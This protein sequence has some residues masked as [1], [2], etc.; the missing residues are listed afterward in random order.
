MNTDCSNNW[1]TIW[2][3]KSAQA[4]DSEE[5]L[6][7]LIKANGFDSGAGDYSVLQWET[8]VAGLIKR[9]AIKKEHKVFE[10]GCG[11]GALLYQLS[12]VSGCA[13]YGIDYSQSLIDSAVKLLKG[14]FKACAANQIPFPDESFDIAISHSV[15][16]YFPSFDYA[17]DVMQRMQKVL[18]KDGFICIMDLNDKKIE[19]I[20]SEERRKS[21]KNP[22]EYEEKYRNFPHLFFDKD[23]IVST[24]GKLG[25]TEIRFFPHD[26]PE[27]LNSRFRFNVI[28]KKA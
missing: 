14:T 25:F 21:A 2:S 9:L 8:M 1:H 15:F 23:E 27:Y 28:A 12:K 19:S 5:L 7:A 24:L 4:D 18:K 17:F 6:P 26:V 20:Y 16:Q 10:V 22:E 11:S 3:G 13:I